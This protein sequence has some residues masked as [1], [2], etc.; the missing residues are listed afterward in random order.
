MSKQT[1]ALRLFINYWGKE[2]T[3]E[4]FYRSI[5]P[6]GALSN[7]FCRRPG[8]YAA[9]INYGGVLSCFVND[10]L[11]AV[12]EANP[13]VVHTMNCIS[14]AGSDDTKM[15]AREC[16]ALFFRICLPNEIEPRYVENCLHNLKWQVDK[17]GMN[18]PRTPQIC[19]T[20]IVT[21]QSMQEVYFCYVM[22]EPIPMYYRLHKQIQRLYDALSR[23][24]HHLWDSYHY[25]D[26]T[27]QVVYRYECFKP[28]PAN[29]FKTYPVV[30]T[31]LN[32]E[33]CV[34]Y[35][36]GP[37][38]T[39]DDLNLLVPKSAR[40]EVYAP[41]MSLEE[42]KEKYPD[43]YHRRIE[44]HR[45]SS[46]QRYFKTNEATYSW[47]LKTVNDNID[48]VALGAME[49]LASYACKCQ[50]GRLT[51]SEDLEDLHTAL[52]PRFPEDQIA[53]HH[54]RALEFYSEAAG[55]LTTWSIDAINKW[56]GLNIQRSKRN[57][58]PQKLHLK[59]VHEAH[60]YKKKVRDWVKA[61]PSGNQTECA[62]E[63][64][65]SR[66]TACKWWP[67]EQVATKNPCPQCGS[68]MERVK[69]EPWFWHKK[70]KKY[71]RINQICSNTECG[72]VIKGRA[73]EIK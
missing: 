64:G 7:V 9:R 25:D 18:H 16:Y 21:S 47:F 63:L 72:H 10:D 29:V 50:I 40:V 44:Q 17:W 51:L 71:T 68:E 70:G 33:T 52:A 65:M 39:I 36:V 35:D 1:D 67:K 57:G 31:K 11:S 69:E 38:Y 26:V 55:P 30:G 19:P 6:E 53:E 34:A 37:K 8:K 61:H 3:Q 41:Q 62:A 20:Y 2:V 46:G 28:Q 12:I 42:A 49:A 4:V 13:D 45:K 56:S 23:A 5:F 58:L 43:W 22:Q 24:I 27:R 15:L 32:G 54:E 59:K 73:Y 14:Y 66:Q 48:T 60:S